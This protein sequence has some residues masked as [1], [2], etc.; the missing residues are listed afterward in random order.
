MFGFKVIRQYEQGLVFD[1]M[2]TPGAEASNGA[3]EVPGAAP[4]SS[5]EMNGAD[6]AA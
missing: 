6:A 4:M 1:R 2:S 3:L 5:A